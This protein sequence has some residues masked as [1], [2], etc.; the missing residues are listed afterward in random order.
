MPKSILKD[1]HLV[2][3]SMICFC[4]MTKMLLVKWV[5]VCSFDH[6]VQATESVGMWPSSTQ[7]ACCVPHHCQRILGRAIPGTK[8]CLFVA[9]VS[10]RHS[11]QVG[12]FELFLVLLSISITKASHPLCR[13]AL[14]L[15]AST[16]GSTTYPQISGCIEVEFMQ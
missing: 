13:R 1:Y 4:N 5:E 14:P 15:K 10:P 3:H 8:E 6:L 11:G 16:D 7:E 2:L 12:V 9:F